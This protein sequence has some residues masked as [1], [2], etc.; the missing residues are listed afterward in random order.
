[1]DIIELN[2]EDERLYR[3]VARLVMNKKVLA[4][5]HNYPFKTSAAHRWFVAM[6][7]ESGVTLGFLPIELVKGKATINNYWVS[8]DDHAVFKALL[9]EAA[10]KIP[11]GTKIESVVQARHRG[12]FEKCGF[13]A[14]GFWVKFA[15]MTYS[16]DVQERL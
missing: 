16:A 4:Y 9:E 10:R 3:T 15:K 1:M 8:E 6:E 7:K 5:N 12:I 14:T 13:R 11:A 2:G